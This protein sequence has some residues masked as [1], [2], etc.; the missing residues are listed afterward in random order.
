MAKKSFFFEF[1]KVHMHPPGS[2]TDS[3]AAHYVPNTIVIQFSGRV[4]EYQR[5]FP[6]E[7]GVMLSF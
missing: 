1:L 3:A 5:E 6:S 7:F 2:A 4:L